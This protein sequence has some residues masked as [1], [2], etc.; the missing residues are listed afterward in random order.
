ATE[1]TTILPGAVFGPAVGKEAH[2]SLQ[3]LQRML[4]GKLPG[5]FRLAFWVVD[6]RDLAALHVRAMTMPAAANE[7]FL[8]TGELIGMRD[9]APALRDTL[10][11]RAAKV[12]R[13]ELPNWL[14]RGLALLV[15]LLRGLVPE[16]G[17]RN[18]VTSAKAQRVLGFAPRPAAATI[19]DS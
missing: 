19:A 3:I 5:L 14:V 11:A 18:D 17:R 6:V 15:P 1:L 9:I 10:G 2:S 12:P 4:D 8:P 16:L 13:R 7:R